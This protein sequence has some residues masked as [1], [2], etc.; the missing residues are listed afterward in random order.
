M[1]CKLTSV[2]KARGRGCHY[3][4]GTAIASGCYIGCIDTQRVC[5]RP[6]NVSLVGYEKSGSV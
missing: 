4:Q 5:Q 6:E 3:I 1:S 2:E